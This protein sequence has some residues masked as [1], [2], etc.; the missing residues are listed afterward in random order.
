MR[1]AFSAWTLCPE[2]QITHVPRAEG[3]PF[4]SLFPA[5]LLL[6]M[7]LAVLGVFD[8]F[9]QQFLLRVTQLY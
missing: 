5:P 1:H 3:V 7:I 8:A 4:P 9:K 2:Q 6:G